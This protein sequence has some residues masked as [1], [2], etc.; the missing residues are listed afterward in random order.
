MAM[1]SRVLREQ[2]TIDP[3][4][5]L[6]QQ[7]VHSLHRQVNAKDLQTGS[8]LPSMAETNL[9]TFQTMAPARSLSGSVS[10]SWASA[11]SGSEGAR[12][13][14]EAMNAAYAELKVDCVLQ[15]AFSCESVEEKRRWISQVNRHAQ[16]ACRCLPDFK[17]LCDNSKADTEDGACV[18]TDIADLAGNQAFCHEHRIF[19]RVPA[20]DLF[21]V[22]TSC[23]DINRANVGAVRK[24]VVL[25]QASS[26]GGSA[27]T[28]RGL[29]DYLDS[30]K[31][32]IVLFENV[33]AIEDSKPSGGSNLDVL[34]NEF[35]SR[36][37][38]GQVVR[39]DALEFGLSC[40]R[41]RIFGLFVRV[42]GSPL[43]DFSTRPMEVVFQTFRSLLSGCLYSSPCLSKVLY[44]HEHDAMQEWL[45][46]RQKKRSGVTKAKK[47]DTA[48]KD[49]KGKDDGAHSWL[50][51]HMRFAESKGIRFTGLHKPSHLASNPWF[52]VLTKREQNA[53]ILC[54]QENRSCLIRDVA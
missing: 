50:E 31:P 29:L 23:K 26:K 14:T 54:Q 38:E 11:C 41:R 16:E 17:G 6:Q 7:Q 48:S 43:F 53:L 39:T 25:N 10:L 51:A 27:Q 47:G 9:K 12:F 28:F 34:K 21:I 19:C 24:E 40:H 46:E 8:Y 18:F 52:Q 5:V 49:N 33:D 30:K 42:V 37:F 44:S 32:A 45:L 13:V 4:T 15:H 20:V 3:E 2:P 35:S 22:G 1:A 36:G